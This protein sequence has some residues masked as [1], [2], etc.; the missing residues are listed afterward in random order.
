[1]HLPAGWLGESDD[2]AKALT[3]PA[4][5]Q[6]SGRGQRAAAGAQKCTPYPPGAVH[7]AASHSLTELKP[8]PAPVPV[9]AA[10]VLECSAAAPIG[11]AVELTLLRD[12]LLHA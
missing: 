7:I 12:R 11:S 5:L 2:R 8:G 10:T 9:G 4:V 6:T 1:M 3:A